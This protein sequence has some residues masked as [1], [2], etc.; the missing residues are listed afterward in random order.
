M[1]AGVEIG[2]NLECLN[3]KLSMLN[4]HVKDGLGITRIR[5][6]IAWAPVMRKLIEL[7]A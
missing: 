2:T 1:C 6:S 3:T 4:I 7:K 5:R